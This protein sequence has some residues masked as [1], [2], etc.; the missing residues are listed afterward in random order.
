[1]HKQRTFGDRLRA[2]RVY[3]GLSRTEVAQRYDI[4][5][6]TLKSWEF[7]H[8]KDMTPKSLERIFHLFQREG[9]NCPKE[10]L[11]YR[12]GP[13]PFS[14]CEAD[15]S[16][17]EEAF[18]QRKNEGSLTYVVNNNA[19]APF[20]K[21]GDRVGGLALESQ[22]L[23]HKLGAFCLF[24][25]GTQPCV[26]GRLVNGSRPGKYSI[27]LDENPSHPQSLMVDAKFSTAHEVVWHRR[28][29]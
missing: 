28:R 3:T 13:S 29:P 8:V 1:M 14:Q 21:K 6:V 5:A 24:S 27:Q 20:F 11:L 18:F 7:G 17:S 22:D 16:L 12:K 2:L 4:P 10:W 23:S 15:L 19:L 9:M 25:F 26:L